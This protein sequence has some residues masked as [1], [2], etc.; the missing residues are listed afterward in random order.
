MRSGMGPFALET[1]GQLT[2]LTC[3]PIRQCEAVVH[4]FSTRQGGVSCLPYASLN[5]SAGSGDDPRHVQENRRRFSHAVGYDAPDLVALRQ[6][7]GNRVAVLAAGS[8]PRIVRG[9]PGDALLTDR[10]GVPLAVITAD[11][12]PVVLVAPH[13]P[14]VGIIHSGRKGTA[15]GVVPT[16]VELMCREFRLRPDAVF[17]AIG[18]GIGGC[19]YEVDAASAEPF[20]TQYADGDAVHRPSRP[21]HVYLDLQ[22]VILRQLEAVGV[23]SSQVWSADLCT[24]CHPQWFYSYRRDGPRSGRMLNV[25]MIRSTT[26]DAP[27]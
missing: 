15:A 17:G 27:R 10:P 22:R 26:R 12:F 7:H 16:A 5:L 4:A 6:V 14:A 18:P 24:A 2:C 13:L 1:T 25:V 21:G 23:P 20:I 8:D 3:T 19:C 9:T 11:C